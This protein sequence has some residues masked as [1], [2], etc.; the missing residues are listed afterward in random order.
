MTMMDN[1]H[2]LTAMQQ[3][4]THEHGL[5]NQIEDM[6]E[7]TDMEEDSIA[8]AMEDSTVDTSTLHFKN[9]C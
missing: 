3:S 6:T 5:P 7:A 8:Y 4:C 1:V 2:K 9:N